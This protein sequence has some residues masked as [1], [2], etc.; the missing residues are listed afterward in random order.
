M[1]KFNLDKEKDKLIIMI[2]D[3]P[4]DNKQKATNDFDYRIFLENGTE[5]DLSTLEEDIYADIYV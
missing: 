2:S 4:T 3:Y 1:D 5:L